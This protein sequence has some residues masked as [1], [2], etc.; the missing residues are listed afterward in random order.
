LP[1]P[2]PSEIWMM[3]ANPDGRV[4]LVR[5]MYSPTV[6]ITVKP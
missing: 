3:A 6:I 1:R 4:L 2:L 5:P